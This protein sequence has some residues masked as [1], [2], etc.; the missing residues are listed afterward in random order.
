MLAEELDALSEH[1]EQPIWTLQEVV[2]AAREVP[3]EHQPERLRVALGRLIRL[4]PPW[5]ATAEAPEDPQ[6]SR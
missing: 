1:S 6:T 3:F 5:S 2:E 4:E